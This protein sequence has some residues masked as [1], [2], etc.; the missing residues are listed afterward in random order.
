MGIT[1]FQAGG[2]FNMATKQHPIII[3]LD[4]NGFIIYQDTLSNVWQFPFSQDLVQNLDIV[5]KEQL[6]NSIGSFI[7]TNK[8]IPSSLIIIL[9]DSVIFQKDLTFQQKN[10]EEGLSPD[11]T[12]N[13]HPT[14]FGNKEQQENEIKNFLDTVPFEEILAKVVN[15]TKIV[16]ANK[17]LLEAVAYPFKKMGCIVH[18]IVPSFMYQQYIDFSG[19]LNQDIA[20]IILQQTDLLKLGNMLTGQQTTEAQQDLHTQPQKEPKEKPN[21]LRQLMLI[22]IF[23]ILFIGLVIV[24]LTLGKTPQTPP[25]SSAPSPTAVLPLQPTNSPEASVSPPEVDLKTIKITIVGNKETEILVNILKNLLTKSGF[26][27]VAT[28]DSTNPIPAKSSVLFSKSVTDDARQK[29]IV[30]IKKIFPDILVQESQ[31]IESVI[32]IIVGKST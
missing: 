15:N 3:F 9:S 7:Q 13:K 10:P 16:A 18:A 28:K 8:I 21:N 26:Q 24:Y 31:D 27:N 23:L 32:T 4:R 12:I 11:K 30:E 22:G 6:V 5:N 14:D 29:A 25:S 17:E 20:K 19:G 2:K 1:H